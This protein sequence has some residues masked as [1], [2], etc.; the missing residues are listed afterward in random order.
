MTDVVVIGAG[1]AGVLAALRA[2]ELG[3]RPTLVSSAQFGG[4]AANDGPVPVRALAYAARLMRDAR[5]LPRYGITESEPVLHYDRLLARVREIVH[6]VGTRAALRERVDALGVTLHERSGAARFTDSHTIET[7]RG[8]QATGR[9]VHHLHRRSQPAPRHPRL[10][11]HDAIAIPAEMR[12]DDSRASP[13]PS[14]LTARCRCTRRCARRPSCGCLWAGR[15]RTSA[16]GRLPH[17]WPDDPRQ[18]SPQ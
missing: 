7:E 18:L 4:M 14:R 2:A 13:F 15:L 5:Q 3:A 10:R 1:P 9:P 16:S 17:E 12:V 8:L 11:A 6:D